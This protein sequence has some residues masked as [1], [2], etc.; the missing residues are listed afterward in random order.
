MD[1]SLNQ[2]NPTFCLEVARECAQRDPRFVCLLAGGGEEMRSRLAERVR[3]WGLEKQIL[4]LGPRKDVPT[5]MSAADLLLFPSFQEGLGMVA[6]EAQAA[7]LPVV[8]SD[9]VPA[10]C[11]VVD[12]MVDFLPLLSGNDMWANHVMQKLYQPKPDANLANQLVTSS[13]FSIYNSAKRLV[14]V[15][16]GQI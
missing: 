8:A 3:S 15:Y 4:L 10:E 16:S 14:Q 1:E 9:T 6:V 11:K 12:S 7:G 2:K 5:L 13:N